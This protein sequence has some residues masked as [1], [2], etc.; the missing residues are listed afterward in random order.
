MHQEIA[1][2]VGSRRDSF[3]NGWDSI[4]LRPRP[5]RAV[6]SPGGQRDLPS[7]RSVRSAVAAE[8]RRNRFNLYRWRRTR[9]FAKLV[10]E[11]LGTF[12][13]LLVRCF[14]KPVVWICLAALVCFGATGPVAGHRSTTASAPDASTPAAKVRQLSIAEKPW[15]GDFE[16]MVERRMIRVLVPYSRTLYFNDK[17]R[18][19]GLTAE[20]V[21]DFEQYVNR[22]LKTGKRPITVYLIPTTRD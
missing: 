8:I 18:E 16:R 10:S 5:S 17:G 14:K 21:R 7:R 11:C 1:C 4:C 12:W 13:F 19:R 15:M 2:A 9:M 20:L 22:K 3:H 6:E